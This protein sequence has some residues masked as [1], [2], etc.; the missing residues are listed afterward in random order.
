MRHA[1][2]DHEVLM[3][4]HT[5]FLGLP[6]SWHPENWRVYVDEVPQVDEPYKYPL[7]R[8]WEL[9]AEHIEVDKKV[10]TDVYLMKAKDKREL[11]KILKNK[12]HDAVFDLFRSLLEKLISDNYHVF[13]NIQTFKRLQGSGFVQ[14]R[15]KE[16][17]NPNANY[18]YFVSMLHPNAFNK[19]FESLTF[20]GADIEYTLLYKWFTQYHGDKWVVND[21]I[22]RRLR[23]ARHIGHLITIKYFT[24]RARG[25]SK[26]FG[27][28]DSNIQDMTNNEAVVSL[29]TAMA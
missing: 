20:L 27:R 7:P 22:K 13:A 1:P 18:L 3:I 28:L 8:N 2:Y 4:T 5:A 21:D 16:N 24:D 23:P 10:G 9:L 12:A 29:P 17:A 15:K 25:F 11:E 6:Y 19:G 26:Y 14:T